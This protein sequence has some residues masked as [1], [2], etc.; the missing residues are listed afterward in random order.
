MG[1]A[2]TVHSAQGVTADS[3]YAILG[4]GASRAMLYVAMTRGRHNNEAF[5]YQ[6][7]RPT[8]PTTNTPNRRPATAI[9]V[10]RRGNKYSAAHHFRMI[11]ANDD[12][13]RTMHAEAERAQQHLLPEVVAGLL[14]RHEERRLVRRTAWQTHSRN[15]EAWLTGGELMAAVTRDRNVSVEA[16]SLGM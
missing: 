15:K 2:T 5:L 16:A 9:H 10:A 12:R 8:R 14:K 3:C 7:L 4:E 1:Y 13:P 11:L 6:R